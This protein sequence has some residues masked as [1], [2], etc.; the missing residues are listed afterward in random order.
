M[1][2]TE[3]KSRTP[4][5]RCWKFSNRN[6]FVIICSMNNTTSS[7]RVH[8]SFFGCTNAGKSSLVNAFIGQELSIVSKARGCT[9]DPVSKSM[10]LLPLGPCVI[11]DTAGLD[12]NGDLGQLRVCKTRQILDRT[13]IGILTVDST[14]G[15]RNEDILVC[16]DFMMRQIPFVV[17]L[18][19]WDLNHDRNLFELAHEKFQGAAAVVCVSSRSG[20]GIGELKEKIGE[21]GK[22]DDSR[23]LF[24]GVVEPGSCVVLVIPVD[25]AA[26]KQRIILPQQ[27]AVR[28]LLDLNCSVI[29]CQPAGLQRVLDSMKSG[30]DL[31]VTDSQAFGEVSRILGEEIPLTSFSILM[32]RFKGFLDVAVN[33]VGMIEKLEDGDKVLVSEGCSH[34]RQCGDIGTVKIPRAL[35]KLTGKNILIETSSGSDFPDNLSEYK[36]IIHCGGCM[37]TER[38]VQSRMKLAQAQQIPFTNYGIFLAHASGILE[39]SLLPLK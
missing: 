2:R 9:T 4:E 31:V 38:E 30:P 12:D 18:N 28:S 16:R 39:R 19:K 1:Q 35:K 29:C 26:P 17:A 7:Q 33:A 25:E 32:A 10:E 8:V 24:D 34:H 11:T 23:G 27:M 21:L 14:C 3:A 20:H 6:L 5:G 37:I 15:V 22:A 13:D 36:M